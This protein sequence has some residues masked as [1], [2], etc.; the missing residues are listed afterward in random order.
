MAQDGEDYMF[1]SDPLSVSSV[2]SLYQSVFLPCS[3]KELHVLSFHKT[4]PFLLPMPWL[5]IRLR[6]LLCT[7]Q[8]CPIPSPFSLYLLSR[9]SPLILFSI[10]ALPSPVF[11]PPTSDLHFVQPTVHTPFLP[12]LLSTSPSFLLS[13]P[14]LIIRLRHLLCSCQ[15]RPIPSRRFPIP[16]LLLSSLLLSLPHL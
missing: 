7:C 11:L 9:L 6:H 10:L 15:S 3:R 14:W 5:I 13:M 16:G 12:S 4:L 8:S 1:P 2:F